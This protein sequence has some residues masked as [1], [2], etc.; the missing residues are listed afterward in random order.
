MN[1]I[2]F[3]ILAFISEI[4]GT[5]GGFGSSIFLV[6]LAGFYFDF[7]TVLAITA[8]MHVFSNISKLILF[9]KDINMRLLLLIGIPAVIFV[10]I[11]SWLST[12]LFLKYAELTLGIFLILFSIFFFWKPDFQLKQSKPNAI[13]GGTVSGF[14]AGLIGTGGAIRGLSLAAFN[15]EKSSFIATSAAIDFFVDLSRA[16]VYLNHDY[17]EKEYYVIIPVLVFIAFAGSYAGKMILKKL[18]NA[19]FKNIVLSLILLI[20]LV[21]VWKTITAN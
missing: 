19:Q 16:V 12:I 6:S 2:L 8:L 14:L 1:F 9:R 5:I 11:G 3:Y 13:M 17:L 4:I 15:L 21:M 10:I 18:T 7:Q 20:G